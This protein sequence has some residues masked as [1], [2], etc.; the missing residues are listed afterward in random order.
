MKTQSMSMRYFMEHDLPTRQMLHSI[1]QC[2]VDDGDPVVIYD[3]FIKRGVVANETS[4][5]F[6]IGALVRLKA[7]NKAVGVWKRYR[8]CEGMGPIPAKSRIII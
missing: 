2:V 1:L 3:T 8:T 7:T 6:L 5:G 4:I